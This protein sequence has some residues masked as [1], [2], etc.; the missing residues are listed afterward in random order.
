MLLD[1]QKRAEHK[2][3]HNRNCRRHTIYSFDF[4]FLEYVFPTIMQHHR[5]STFQR[6]ETSA[7]T[8]GLINVR[9]CICRRFGS[10]SGC[11]ACR[12]DSPPIPATVARRGS[13]RTLRSWRNSRVP[14]RR[15]PLCYACR[16]SKEKSVMDTRF[17]FSLALLLAGRCM[18]GCVSVAHA[19]AQQPLYTPGPPVPTAP[20]SS[21]TSPENEPPSAART[22]KRTAVAKPVHHRGRSMVA[23]RTLPFYWR[24]Y[25]DPRLPCCCCPI[26]N[27]SGPDYGGGWLMSRF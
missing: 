9:S 15:F 21:V 7:R 4:D 11:R 18:F 16:T 2:T 23:G 17:A 22:H 13:L 25:W 1:Y 14:K 8:I 24:I 3:N 27:A 26:W 19:Q 20:G 12:G 5:A 10:S 6:G